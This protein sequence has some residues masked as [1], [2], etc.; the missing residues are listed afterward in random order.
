[1]TWESFRAEVK[2]GT[3]K[4]HRPH[5]IDVERLFA[6]DYAK[7]LAP[8][9]AA[10]REAHYEVAPN[11]LE[12]KALAGLETDFIRAMRVGSQIPKG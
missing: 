5:R 12:Y 2:L 7:A 6:V 10:M 1:M 4:G 8:K 3:F 9:I 11:E